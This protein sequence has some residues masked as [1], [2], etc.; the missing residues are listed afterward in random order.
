MTLKGR[1]YYNRKMSIKL[2]RL[3][4]DAYNWKIVSEDGM[5]K[6]FVQCP[7]TFEWVFAGEVCTCINCIE[8]NGWYKFIYMRI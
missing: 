7:E 2:H 8:K 5:D 1:Y 4:P 6:L 3:I